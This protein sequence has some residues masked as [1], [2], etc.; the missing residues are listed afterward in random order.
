MALGKVFEHCADVIRLDSTF[1]P[2]DTVDGDHWNTVPIA[3][4][5]HGITPDI[6]L[7]EGEMVIGGEVFQAL[8][9]VIAQVTASFRKEHNN[10]SHVRFFQSAYRSDSGMA[11]SGG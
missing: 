8:P 1:E 7:V 4:E 9:C 6:H 3:L 5:D 11:H 10:G 2:L